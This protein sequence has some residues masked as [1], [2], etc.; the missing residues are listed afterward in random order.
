MSLVRKTYIVRGNDRDFEVRISKDKQPVDLRDVD[1]FCEIKD[2][3]NGNLLFEA[4]VMRTEA[5]SQ[6]GIFRVRFPKER[7]I[8]LTVGKKVFFDFRFVF[9]D[10]TE[11]NFPVPPIEAIVVDRVTD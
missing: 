4:I 7:T 6:N 5:E 3:P 11:K 8:G 10:G 2:A 1:I 9:P